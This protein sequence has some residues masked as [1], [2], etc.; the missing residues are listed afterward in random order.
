MKNLEIPALG[1]YKVKKKASSYNI[2]KIIFDSF[3]YILSCCVY[4]YFVQDSHRD[5]IKC[6]LV[7]PS[8]EE[9]IENV[10]MWKRYMFLSK[11]LF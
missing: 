10:K 1:S 9:H 5:P 3:C 11:P 7:D 6:F 4:V 8:C 2:S